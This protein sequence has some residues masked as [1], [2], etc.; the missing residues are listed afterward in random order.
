MT[1]T[2]V[3]AIKTVYNGQQMI[4]GFV[5]GW[6]Q[7][8]SVIPTKASIGVIWSQNALETGATTSRFLCDPFV[9]L[10]VFGDGQVP[11]ELAVLVVVDPLHQSPTLG[12]VT[13][14]TTMADCSTDIQSGIKTKPVSLILM[15]PHHGVVADE[16]AHLWAPIV[17]AVAE[18]A[19]RTVITVEV[20]SA[21]IWSAIA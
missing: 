2:L 1:A 8:F 16:L 18:V 13:S 19:N 3:P 11:G 4:A 7:Q 17:W 10:Q 9:V 5:Q 14:V 12:Y 21:E 15:E 20:N 6:V